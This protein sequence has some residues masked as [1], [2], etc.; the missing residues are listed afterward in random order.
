MNMGLGTNGYAYDAVRY[1]RLR[2]QGMQFLK[3]LKISKI[4]QMQ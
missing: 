4:I 2:R 1:G 3:N